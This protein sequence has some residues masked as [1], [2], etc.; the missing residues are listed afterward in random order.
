MPVLENLLR[1]LALWGGLPVLLVI[2]AIGPSRTWHGLKNA[3]KW[4]WNR[5]LDPEDVLN[6]VVKE[7]EKHVAALRSVLARSEV[8]EAEILRNLETSENNIAALEKEAAKTVANGDDLGARAVLYKLNLER[9]AVDS[10]RVQ[11]ERQRN[12]LAEV[13]RHLYLTELQTR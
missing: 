3:W 13:R 1:V 12:H 11:L 2:L 9:A 4:L 7:H 8:A 5:R 6:R 10:F